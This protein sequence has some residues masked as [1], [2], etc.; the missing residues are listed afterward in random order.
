MILFSLA[1]GKW[2]FFSVSAGGPGPLETRVTQILGSLV[3]NRQML[4]D[5]ARE[6]AESKSVT[7]SAIA[8]IQGMKTKLDEL[9][10]VALERDALQAEIAALS[11]EL[12]AQQKNLADAMVV[13]TVAQPGAPAPDNGVTGAPNVEGTPAEATPETVA[14]AAEATAAAVEGAAPNP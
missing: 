11:T 12:D 8:F 2:Q 4:E 3:E 1:I 14:A 5:L 10:N 7:E 9:A 6:V 13:G